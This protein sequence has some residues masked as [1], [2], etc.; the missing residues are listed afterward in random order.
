MK[1]TRLDSLRRRTDDTRPVAAM[2]LAAIF[3]GPVLVIGLV[4]LGGRLIAS[5]IGDAICADYNS[6]S[7]DFCDEWHYDTPPESGLPNFVSWKIEWQEL[8]CGSGGCPN[9]MYVLSPDGQEGSLE[10]YTE[11][12]EK[13][14]WELYDDPQSSDLLTYRKGDL[15]LDV[16]DAS[17]SYLKPLYPPNLRK[18]DHVA[19]SLG[20]IDD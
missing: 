18:Q 5:A 9:R 13:D 8:S 20:L 16:D 12:L 1:R 19:V 14:G 7:N 3:L 11:M 15:T 2:K 17:S 6:L 4:F 10:N